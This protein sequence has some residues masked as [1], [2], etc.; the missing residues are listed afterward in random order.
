MKNP[1]LNYVACQI[2]DLQ[3]NIR[4]K[5]PTAQ[6]LFSKGIAGT[7]GS[8]VYGK[9]VPA[10]ES[11]MILVPD[12]KTLIPLPWEPDRAR[13]ICNVF[14]PPKKE[15]SP[16]KPFEGCSRSILAK[17]V[18]NMEKTL[19][20]IVQK[21]FPQEKILKIRAYF[22]PEVEFLLLPETYDFSKIHL[23]PAFTNK[24]YFV[25]PT[26]NVNAA[27]K[28]I[29]RCLGLMGLKKEVYHT[30]VATHQYEIGIG[31]GNVMDIADGTMTIKFIIE[32]V[33][34]EFGLRAY[35]IPKFNKNVNGSG[36]HV[37]QNLSLTVAGQ[38]GKEKRINLFFD[39]TQENSLSKI[40]QQYIAGLL[41]YA[42]E[43]TAITNSQT[44]SFKRLV[45]NAEAPTHIAF[46][47]LNRTALCRGHSPGIKSI[48]V[49]YRAPDPM[50]NPYLAYAAML[51]AGMAGIQE[52]LDLPPCRNI[53]FHIN[54][55]GI[56]E[57]PGNLGEAL[58]I[59]NESQMLR[60]SLGNFI[61]DTLFKLGQITWQEYCREITDMDVRKYL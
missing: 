36:M 59:M 6:E 27:L 15:D 24:H 44:E 5:T 11:D 50:C 19:L 49:E 33:A 46:D 21:K 30:E 61:I 28:E 8:S 4:E 55:Q 42:K 29:V 43:I 48:R 39:P 53:D 40:G 34:R 3:G 10:T 17:V 38:D 60:K 26:K 52:N 2:I 45:P 18:R 13:V 1:G 22:A 14:Y 20:P 7:D 9:I 31:H 37:H 23:D 35:F 54:S 47:W 16:A 56:E 51:S 12:F 25:P 32:N 41:K 58:K 57:L